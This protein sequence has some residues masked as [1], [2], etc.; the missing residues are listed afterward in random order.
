M[1][2][3]TKPLSEAQGNEKYRIKQPERLYTTRPRYLDDKTTR[4]SVATIRIVEGGLNRKRDY[5]PLEQR[6]RKKLVNDEGYAEFLLQNIQFGF[7]EKSQVMQTFG[8]AETVYYFGKAPTTVSLT[9]LLVDDLDNDW[10]SKFI[11][12]Y[13]SFL[14]GT[15]LA[16]N[17]ELM[18]LELPN[19]TFTGSLMNMNYQQNSQRD[20]DIQFSCTLLLKS[21]RFFSSYQFGSDLSSEALDQEKSNIAAHSSDSLP[22]FTQED[23]NRATQ[24]AAT[25][26]AGG[27]VQEEQTPGVEG[28]T[29]T[30]SPAGQYA[31]NVSTAINQTLG[32]ASD[33]INALSE[34]IS[35]FAEAVGE[36]TEALTSPI[37]EIVGGIN[38]I[39][40]AGIAVVSS[41]EE[42]ADSVLDPL[43]TTISRARRTEQKL[44][45]LKGSITSLP[46]TLSNKASRFIRSGGMANP[47]ILGSSSA[48]IS[49]ADAK[50]TLKSSNH[51]PVS[52]A[53]RVGPSDSESR[54]ADETATLSG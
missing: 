1:P 27:T 25:L 42:T 26:E 41:I 2:T 16:R 4:G 29:F 48:N 54:D 39:A 50:G 45:N 3:N 9:G 51:R 13:N 21:F 17:F 15:E 12:G 49:A 38:D 11:T 30:V 47:P 46:E 37:D 7:S 20:A 52:S 33:K 40:G 23:V 14:R 22:T 44:K 6:V 43:T 10:F 34:R 31:Q 5:S 28:D 32:G 18:R 19:A 8:D 35:G 53:G 24:Q 36:E